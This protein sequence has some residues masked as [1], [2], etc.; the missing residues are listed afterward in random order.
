[1][2]L[3][4]N[5][6]SNIIALV[7]GKGVLGLGPEFNEINKKPNT[8]LSAFGVTSCDEPFLLLGFNHVSPFSTTAYR[9]AVVI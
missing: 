1:M 2:R 3:H 7:C 8:A 6:T 4:A 9:P 5:V